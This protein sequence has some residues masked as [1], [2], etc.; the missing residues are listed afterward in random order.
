MGNS[1]HACQADCAAS[2]GAELDLCKILAIPDDINAEFA[3]TPRIE[4]LVAHHLQAKAP[5]RLPALNLRKPGET[6][7]EQIALAHVLAAAREESMHSEGSADSEDGYHSVQ[8]FKSS[9]VGGSA[10]PVASSLS[11]P[12]V[13]ATVCEDDDRGTD[14]HTKPLEKV[15]TKLPLPLH[16]LRKPDETFREQLAMSRV[17]AS[18]PELTARSDLSTMRGDHEGTRALG[19]VLEEQ[20]AAVLLQTWESNPGSLT[21]REFA[22]SCHEQA[23]KELLSHAEV[24]KRGPADIPKLLLRRPGETYREQVAMAKATAAAELTYRSDCSATPRHDSHVLQAFSSGRLLAYASSNEAISDVTALEQ[25]MKESESPYLTPGPQAGS[26]ARGTEMSI[27]RSDL[28]RL[29]KM[30]DSSC[31]GYSKAAASHIAKTLGKGS[32]ENRFVTRFWKDF[33]DE[34]D[35][36]MKG[37]VSKRERIL[38]CASPL[39]ARSRSTPA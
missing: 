32:I 28:D 12:F 10:L 15:S 8:E 7:R 17:I 35:A 27:P 36:S 20:S 29:D 39:R 13:H 33:P 34:V 5:L 6:H 38:A 31:Q 22:R 11:S 14:E 3:K 19:T 37:S 21:L 18:S 30:P 23:Q 4:P 2:V 26:G 1:W 16:K 24:L 25:Y 9:S